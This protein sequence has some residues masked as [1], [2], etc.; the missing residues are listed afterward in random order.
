MTHENRHK[1]KIIALERDGVHRMLT[2]PP[3]IKVSR[4]SYEVAQIWIAFVCGNIDK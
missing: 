1:Y 4:Q 3:V 2:I